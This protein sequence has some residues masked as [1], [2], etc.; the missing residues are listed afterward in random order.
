M[1]TLNMFTLELQQYI[2]IPCVNTT[3]R[4]N[5]SCWISVKCSD[6]TIE[7]EAI[8]DDLHLLFCISS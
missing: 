3:K 7:V 5:M 8:F 6:E 2:T 1:T 4:E